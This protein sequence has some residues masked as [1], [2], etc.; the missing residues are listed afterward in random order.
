MQ[1]QERCDLVNNYDGLN[2]YAS[3][4]I[5]N[6]THPGFTGNHH[7]CSY[8]LM[9]PPG[10][11]SKG[12]IYVVILEVNDGTTVYLSSSDTNFKSDILN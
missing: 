5:Q 4:T 2:I 12:T 3:N 11:Y 9:N 10:G 8:Q 6:F 1:T 7:V